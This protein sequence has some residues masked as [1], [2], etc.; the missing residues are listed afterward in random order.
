MAGLLIAATATGRTALVHQSMAGIYNLGH[1]QRWCVCV[2]TAKRTLMQTSNV[3]LFRVW[4]PP[5]A[6]MSKSAWK[7]C[8]RTCL[9]KLRLVKSAA[10]RSLACAPGQVPCHGGGPRPAAGIP[11]Q[12]L[13]VHWRRSRPHIRVHQPV[14]HAARAGTE[15]GHRCAGFRSYS[16]RLWL[17]SP[18]HVWY[19]PFPDPTPHPFA[20][21][22]VPCGCSR[23]AQ[24]C[25]PCGPAIQQSCD[26]IPAAGSG[27]GGGADPS[28]A[29][30]TG[31]HAPRGPSHRGQPESHVHQGI[32]AQY[33]AL[34]V[35][36][37]STTAWCRGCHSADTRSSHFV[38][39]SLVSVQALST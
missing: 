35:Q 31:L 36:P 2:S 34:N 13:L 27:H 4:V 32:G 23:G 20:A 33:A 21:A 24:Q 38:C 8:R 37:K 25:S 17:L 39:T 7:R 30:V 3:L 15:R 18:D 16:M 11:V 5:V 12:R 1:I 29:T 26:D 9:W 19:S 22:G 10:C 6:G 14:A 28:W